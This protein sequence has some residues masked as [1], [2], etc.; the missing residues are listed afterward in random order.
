MSF[1][2]AL[3]ALSALL[4]LEGVLAA[5][6]ADSHPLHWLILSVVLAVYAFAGWVFVT[7]LLVFHLNLIRT[8]L[9]TNEFCK[10]SWVLVAGNPFA[11][12]SPPHLGPP[13]GRTC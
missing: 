12:Y 1:L 8:N 11:K 6:R 2:I 4:V 3:T 9:T 10:D 13:A 7:V 5:T